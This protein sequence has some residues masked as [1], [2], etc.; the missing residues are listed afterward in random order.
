[1]A[2]LRRSSSPES[3]KPTSRRRHGAHGRPESRT[4]SRRLQGELQRCSPPRRLQLSIQ[5]SV[6]NPI[7][8]TR[9]SASS[10]NV[11]LVES[12]K[13]ITME[14]TPSGNSIMSDTP[15]EQHHRKP[16]TSTYTD[17]E[18][19]CMVENHFRRL[20]SHGK[21]ERILRKLI[22]RDD[23]LDDGSLDDDALAS[24]LTSA[25]AVFFDGALSRRVQWEW[26]SQDR[27]RTELIGTTA[28]RRCVDRD[29]FETLIVLSEPILKDPRYDRRLLLSAFLHELVHC[30]LFILC[31]FKAR[32]QGG[33]TKG[34]HTIVRIID[35]W[36]GGGYLSLCNMKANLN[37]FRK[38]R[39]RL[40]DPRV[41][42]SPDDRRHGHEGC[43]QS[44]RPESGL[45]DAPGVL[46]GY[47]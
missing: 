24:I 4:W 26:S 23:P 17:A 34:F 30:Y 9:S 7:A 47:F 20:Q 6:P 45:L 36:V 14:R 21:H 41:Q 44:P 39:P 25:D 2:F 1:M 40:L 22:K 35:D 43:S 11:G 19:E 42:G 33:H 18:A 46:P 3:S 29:G 10:P 15:F 8:T 12:A 37:H 38:D 13:G 16:N 31:G 32:M 5:Q 28:L 27:Y